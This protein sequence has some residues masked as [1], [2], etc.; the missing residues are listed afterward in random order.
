MGARN[1]CG[2][3]LC[4]HEHYNHTTRL[5]TPPLHQPAKVERGA[6][7]NHP[8]NHQ[9]P[10]RAPHPQNPRS[11]HQP[12]PIRFDHRTKTQQPHSNHQQ[13]H[14]TKPQ[15]KPTT[16][17]HFPTTTPTHK[18]G[19]LTGALGWGPRTPGTGGGERAPSPTAP[20]PG[21]RQQHSLPANLHSNSI[22]WLFDR[23]SRRAS[24]KPLVDASISAYGVAD[25]SSSHPRSL[26]LTCPFVLVGHHLVWVVTACEQG[27]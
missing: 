22:I 21:R 3:S 17:V 27:V 16:I 2:A 9:Q 7:N 13:P 1:S 24:S 15:V 25:R 5:S 12:S 20:P 10:S 18:P 23:P 14:F 26:V 4:Q 6:R 11:N 8:I 19:C